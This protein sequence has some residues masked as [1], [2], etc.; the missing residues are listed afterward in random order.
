MQMSF[1]VKQK[2]DGFVDKYKE[3]LIA[4]GFTQLMRS[5]TCLLHRVPTWPDGLHLSRL[6][7]D[8]VVMQV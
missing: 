5:C 4:K 8:K 6:W 2:P 7:E 1:K 3:R